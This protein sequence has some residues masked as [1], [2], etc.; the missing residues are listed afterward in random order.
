M[1]E[2]VSIIWLACEAHGADDGHILTEIAMRTAN[3]TQPH[4]RADAMAVGT[5]QPGHPRRHLREEGVQ[6]VRAALHEAS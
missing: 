6:E 2:Y 1:Y 5:A 3:A 4:D